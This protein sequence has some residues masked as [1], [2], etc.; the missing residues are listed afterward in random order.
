M[1]TS[2]ENIFSE[3]ANAT[4]SHIKNDILGQSLIKLNTITEVHFKAFEFFWPL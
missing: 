1:S 4:Q 3:N 2:W